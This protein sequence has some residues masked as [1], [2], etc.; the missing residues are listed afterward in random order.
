[1]SDIEKPYLSWSQASQYLKCPT[2]Y[3]LQRIE[4]AKPTYER[5]G[6][7]FCGQLG[8]KSLE[9]NYL[10]K[11]SSGNDLKPD[12][13]ADHFAALFD[14]ESEPET[15]QWI[16][17]TAQRGRD[18]TI[19]AL[20]AHMKHL[21]PTIQPKAVEKRIRIVLG[22]LPFDLL[23]ILDL[24]TVDDRVVDSKFYGRMKSQAD[25]DADG[26]LTV[27]ALAYMS[28]YGELPTELALAIATRTNTPTAKM[29]ST[30]RTWAQVDWQLETQ[31]KPIFKGIAAEV[32]PARDDGWW[33]SEKWCSFYAQCKGKSLS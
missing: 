24:V 19:A 16:G 29:I 25:A 5:N 15:I 33:C 31:L 26:Q 12:D 8:H 14:A 20:R 27:Y 6:A 23:T 21:A 1:M 17:E 30:K 9:M 10:Q 32:F 22:G 3:R 18:N 11:I 13:V 7:A 28:E 4:K 2:Q